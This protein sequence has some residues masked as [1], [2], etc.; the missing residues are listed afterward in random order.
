M[1]RAQ[2]FVAATSMKLDGRRSRTDSAFARESS[3]VLNQRP[4][5]RSRF[6][7]GGSA[8]WSS[9]LRPISF[10]ADARAA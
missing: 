7:S 4:R 1:L 10:A 2:G 3:G 5:E 6:R 9:R 8:G